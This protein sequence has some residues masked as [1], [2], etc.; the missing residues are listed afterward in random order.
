M[1]AEPTILCPIDFSPPARAGLR[2]A[3]ILAE[4]FGA[5]LVLLTVNDPLLEE[6]AAMELGARW[7]PG[8]TEREL[9]KFLEATVDGGG[10]H[11]ARIE[12][13]VAVGKPAEEI[14]R[15]ARL[16]SADVIVMSTH[17]LTGVRK[18]FFGSTT[19][20]VLRETTVPVLVT[21]PSESGPRTTE[22]LRA[23]AQRILVPV[24]LGPASAHQVGVARAIAEAVRGTL[25]LLHVVEPVRFPLPPSLHWPSVDSERRTRAEAA[26]TELTAGLPRSLRAE[27]L[28]VLGD[29]AEEI[30]KVARARQ[31]GL[32]IIAL[33]GS[34]RLGPRMGSVTYRVLCLTSTLT[35]ALPP[36]PAE[37]DGRRV[38]V[39]EI[40][41]AVD[42]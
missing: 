42:R 32:I 9:R 36:K 28:V 13:E 27:P 39:G 21:P 34:P 24:D 3:L 25:L 26:L 4:H 37:P 1:P 2:Y 19:E 40:D 41:R 11:A 14:L 30:A 15:V 33:H 23:S 12:F 20:R 17:G 5:R 10:P 6:V 29:P 8:D 22:E 18:F 38:E 35:L 7:L 31:V 16:R